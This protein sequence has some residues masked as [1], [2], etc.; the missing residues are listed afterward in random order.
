MQFLHDCF[1]CVSNDF[2]GSLPI[3]LAYSPNRI[4]QIKA[5]ANVVV[6]NAESFQNVMVLLWLFVRV[7]VFEVCR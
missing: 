4:A 7:C 2:C 3:V 1:A 6:S 5:K